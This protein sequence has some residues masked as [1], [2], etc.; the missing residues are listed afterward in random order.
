MKKLIFS[1]LIFCGLLLSAAQTSGQSF[2]SNGS[3]A[4]NGAPILTSPADRS[5]LFAYPE[6]NIIVLR[7]TTG[8][9]RNIDRYVVEKASDS[10]HFNPLHEVVARGSIDGDDSTYQDMDSYPASPVNYYRLKTVRTDGSVFYSAIVRVDVDSR[11]TPILKPTVVHMGSTIRMDNYHEQP[12]TVNFFNASGTL[13]RSFVVN[14]TSFDIPTDGWSKGI[15]F[16][17]ISDA[18]H[19]LI[20]AGKIMIL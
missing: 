10:L 3:F 12:L 8:N 11:K 7:W 19:P 5:G 16:Y 4:N 9:E 18:T 20:N 14:S 2:A 13:M 15:F 1:G 17:R 6:S